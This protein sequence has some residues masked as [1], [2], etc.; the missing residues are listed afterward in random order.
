[1]NQTSTERGVNMIN[2]FKNNVKKAKVGF[3]E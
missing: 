3:K 1:V 2:N